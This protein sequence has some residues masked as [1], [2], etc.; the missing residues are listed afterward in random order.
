MTA[1]VSLDSSIAKGEADGIDRQSEFQSVA[2]VERWLAQTITSIQQLFHIGVDL[3]G[4]PDADA[5]NT[6]SL[7]VFRG[8]LLRGIDKAEQL[9]H[10]RGLVKQGLDLNK[11]GYIHLETQYKALSFVQF[12]ALLANMLDRVLCAPQ[13]QAG[14]HRFALSSVV[15]P[16]LREWNVQL[17][18]HLLIQLLILNGRFPKENI[19]ELEGSLAFEVETLV[20]HFL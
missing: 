15:F 18:V 1:N 9:L 14:V 13:T 8:D 7:P 16:L 20:S 5:G 3:A 4:Y 11:A 6:Q 2:E 17:I 19:K 10:W 12:Q